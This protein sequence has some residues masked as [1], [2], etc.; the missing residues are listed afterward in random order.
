MR[1]IEKDKNHIAP[2]VVE[3]ILILCVHI[4]RHDN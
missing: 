1:M 2:L 3:A 4:Q